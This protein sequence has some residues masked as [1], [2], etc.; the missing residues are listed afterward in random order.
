[1]LDFYFFL[2]R[3]DC[4]N[5]KIIVFAMKREQFL[6][7]FSTYSINFDY[8]LKKSFALSNLILE[9]HYKEEHFRYSYV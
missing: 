3:F 8:I 9:H 5:E 1:M 7:L 6:M 4:I 2:Q